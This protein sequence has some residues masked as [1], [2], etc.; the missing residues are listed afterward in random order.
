MIDQSLLEASLQ[1][2]GWLG[3]TSLAGFVTLHAAWL[4]FPPELVVDAVVDKSKQFSSE[5]RIKVKNNGKLPAL[6]IQADAENVCARIGGLTMDDCG[7]FNG[8]HVFARLSSG[9]SAEFSVSPGIHLGQAMQIS[10]FSYRLTLKYKAKLFFFHK[11]FK[12]SWAVELRNF[13]DGFAWHVT[14]A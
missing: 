5:S 3:V 6:S 2:L 12:K 7:F 10:A 8:P 14:P 4:S 9:E 1:I 13:P 11:S